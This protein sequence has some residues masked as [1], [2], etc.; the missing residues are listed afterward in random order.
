MK[1]YIIGIKNSLKY[2]KIF[3]RNFL[4]FVEFG[5]GSGSSFFLNDG[6]APKCPESATLNR[7]KKLTLTVTTLVLNV[8]LDYM[9]I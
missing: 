4:T 1:Y 2:L 6:S 7:R 5:V 3:D 9:F 8:C